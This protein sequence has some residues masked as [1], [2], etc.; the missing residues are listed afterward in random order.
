MAVISTTRKRFVRGFFWKSRESWCPCPRTRRG[1]V[2]AA[3]VG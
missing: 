2:G 3:G 1:D